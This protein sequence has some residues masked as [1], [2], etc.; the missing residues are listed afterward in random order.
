[1]RKLKFIILTLIAGSTFSC[2]KDYLDVAPKMQATQMGLFETEAGFKDALTGIYIQMKSA[3]LYG[4]NLTITTLEHMVSSWDV[5]VG[6]Y[7]EK[8]NNFNYT[9]ATVDATFS[10]IF[11]AQYKV[12][13][14]INAILDHIDEKKG[15]FKEGMYETIKSECLALRAYVHLD[16]LRLFGPIPTDPQ[17]GNQ[18][19]YV[20]SLSHI[21]NAHLPFA[22]FKELLLKDLAEAETLSKRV[23]PILNYSLADLKNPGSKNIFNPADTYMAYRYLRM[24]YYAVKALQARAY[25]WF[26]DKVKAYECARIVIDAK[27]PD[28]TDKFALGSGADVGNSDYVLTREH[29]F[30]LYDFNMYSTYTSYFQNGLLCKGTSPG[31]LVKTTL[32]GNTGTDV[33]EGF[34]WGAASGK[35]SIL[36]YKVVQTPTSLAVDYKQ[37][38]LLR[39]SEMYLIAIETATQAADAQ[40][41]WSRFRTARNVSVTVLPTDPIALQ[42]ELV[43][44][45]RKEFYAEGQAFYAYKRIKAPQSLIVFAPATA[46]V[47]YL[48][49]MPK[50]EIY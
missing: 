45:F 50:N 23:D 35:W 20:T 33:R 15:L 19:A 31:T 3:A 30:S 43:K 4:Q 9:D 49:P 27:N 14:D 22:Q 24:N 41:L 48:L 36:K 6:S 32:Y 17:N 26:N 1:M 34:L 46:T 11:S 29:I 12:I 25:L 37:I 8:L 42:N 47:N 13:A 18:L 39:V 2:S 38:P 7:Q 16:I 28:G 44:E 40:D 10:G 21:A 5:T